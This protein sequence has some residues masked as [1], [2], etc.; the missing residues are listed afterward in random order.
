MRLHW[1]QQRQVF[2]RFNNNEIRVILIEILYSTSPPSCAA[3]AHLSLRSGGEGVV[4][5][6]SDRHTRHY[7][8]APLICMQFKLSLVNVLF[9]QP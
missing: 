7:I 4:G 8:S 1:K 2:K 6:E 3:W 9:F 5:L